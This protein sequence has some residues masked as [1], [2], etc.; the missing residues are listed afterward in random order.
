MAPAGSTP[1]AAAL[2][3]RSNLL[4]TKP[5]R[6]QSHLVTVVAR[7]PR[8]WLAKARVAKRWLGFPFLPQPPLARERPAFQVE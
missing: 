4:E 2:E 1:A 3:Y 8:R 7:G 6:S 5:A